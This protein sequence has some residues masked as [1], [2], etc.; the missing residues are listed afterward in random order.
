MLS[1]RLFV[2]ETTLGALNLY[3]RGIDAFDDQTQREGDVFA[4]HSAIALIGVQNEAHL[5]AALEHRDAIGT[6]KGIL[7]NRHGIGP[8]E[9]FRLLVEASQAANLKPH[10]VAAW[11]VDHHLD[12]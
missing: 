10:E 6:A 11:L 5:N 2:S 3:S 4:S 1:Y 9:A 7:M 12:V 8:V